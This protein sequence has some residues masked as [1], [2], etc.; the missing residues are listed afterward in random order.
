M[1]END[2]SIAGLHVGDDSKARVLLRAPDG[3]QKIIEEDF[4][5][6]LWADRAAPEAESSEALRGGGGGL[7]TLLRF[8]NVSEYERFLKNRPRDMAIE[9]VSCLENQYLMSGGGRMFLNCGFAGLRRM[10]LDIETSSEAG[11]PNPE[12][13]GDRVIAVGLGFAGETEIIEIE[14]FSDGAEAALL[15]KLERRIIELDPDTIEG[16]NI[17]RFDLDFIRRRL[18]RLKMPMRWGRFGGECS[19][20]NSRVKIAERQFDYLRCDIPGRTVV[21]TLILLQLYDISARE[22]SSYSLK[23]AALHFGFSNKAERTYIDGREIQN[24]FVSDRETFKKYLSDDIR[25][26]R[27]LADRLLPTYVAQVKNFPLTLQECL[28]RGTGVK[29]EYI[30]LEK[31]LAARQALPEVPVAQNGVSGAISATFKRGVFKNVLHYD[32]ASLYP[33]LMLAIG[34][35]PQ[36]DTLKVF[37]DV[38]KDLRAKRLDY[39]KRARLAQNIDEKNELSA[40]QASF[41]I[42]IN[43]FYGYLGL[44]TARFSDAKLADEVTTLGRELLSEIIENFKRRGCEVLEADTDGVYISCGKYFERPEE[45]VNLVDGHLPDGVDLEFDGKYEAM[46]CYK[47]K[48]YAL[49]ENGKAILKGSALRSRSLEG[50]LRKLTLDYINILLGISGEKI[51]DVLEKLEREISSGKCPISMI[52]KCEHLGS[53]PEAYKKTVELSGKGRRAS[54]EA[55]LK[56]NRALKSGDKVCYFISDAELKKGADWKRAYPAEMYD[57]KTLPYDAS[58]YLEK[59]EDWKEKFADFLPKTEPKQGELF[60]F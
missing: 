51:E 54:M 58:Y 28:L 55:A 33:S 1:A 32:V 4:K 42:L 25:E 18:K 30:F 53:N 37:L 23:N 19:F 49:L 46:F 21:D 26:T 45:L 9:K 14:D 35:C 17:F 50:F 3:S 24:F 52:A 34:K 13:A 5:P 36:N 15:S 10:Q 48:N 38:L 57:P 39:K 47:A 11:F 20:R 56:S 31:Y 16:H 59:L 22:L 6:F 12:R 44:A 40:R 8:K 43:S 60:D 41:K 2:F 29:V 7:N 27:E